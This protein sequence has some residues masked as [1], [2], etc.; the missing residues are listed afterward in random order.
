MKKSQHTSTSSLAS[1]DSHLPQSGQ[2]SAPS[3]FQRS[4]PTP[5]QCSESIGQ[6]CPTSETSGMFPQC[7]A[8]WLQVDSHVSRSRLLD[9]EK[10]RTMIATSGRQCWQS[11][12]LVGP[13]GCLARMLLTSKIWFSPIA[14]MRW[15]KLVI[16]SSHS[17]FRLA[18]LD[19]QRWNGTHG[20]LPRLL[21][22]DAKG[23]GKNRW[24]NSPKSRNNFREVIRNGP[25]DGIYPHPEFAEW[26]KGF[27]I[28]WT[29]LNASA[30]PLIRTS[31]KPSSVGSTGSSKTRAQR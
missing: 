19:Y 1:A 30:T 3:A 29:D 9:S 22:S 13:V 2:D 8:T 24:L 28:G 10:E 20:L 6:T 23:A 7:D 26:V 14:L 25:N 4:T 5:P 18:L 27:P 17:I 15:K 21:A 11:S 12:N 16:S 31:P